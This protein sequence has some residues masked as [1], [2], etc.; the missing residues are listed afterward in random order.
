MRPFVHAANVSWVLDARTQNGSKS[1]CHLG[2]VAGVFDHPY[3]IRTQHTWR[4]GHRQMG[5]AK[6]YAQDSIPCMADLLRRQ[7]IG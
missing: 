4:R 3:F 2:T 5:Y 6:L 7:W 1:F